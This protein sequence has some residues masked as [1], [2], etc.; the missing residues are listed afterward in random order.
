MVVFFQ[1]NIFFIKIDTHIRLKSDFFFYRFLLCSWNTILFARDC[2]K[3]LL[4]LRG[5]LPL[6]FYS[7]LRLVRANKT[8]KESVRAHLKSYQ[9][10]LLLFASIFENP[11]ISTSKNLEESFGHRRSTQQ[12]IRPDSISRSKSLIHR[13]CLGVSSAARIIE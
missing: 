12:R 4:Y 9:I 6:K 2:I 11:P 8:L 10:L 13:Q 7:K 3:D 1:I 5:N